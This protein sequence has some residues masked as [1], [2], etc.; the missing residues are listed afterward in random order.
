MSF[1]AVSLQSGSNGNAIFVQ[2]G[3]VNLL[4]D[5]GI[6]GRQAQLRLREKT[7]LDIRDVAAM[8]I[9]H[10]HRDHITS[11][12]IFQR[13]FDLP[14]H[15]SAPTLDAAMRHGLGRLGRVEHFTPG[16]GVRIGA[17]CI[18][19]YPT[20]HDGVDG[21]CFVVEYA[22][23][24]L[25]VM[26]DLGHPFPALGDLIAGCDAVYLE[27]NYDEGMLAAGLYPEFLK[28]RIRG[29]G[30]HISNDEAAG[31]LSRHGR[32]LQWAALAHLSGDN[33]TPAV[34]LA[35]ARQALGEAL[36]VHLAGRDGP[37]LVLEIE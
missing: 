34:A 36:P 18:E 22:G 2:A 4:F 20:P 8:F 30:G 27:S 5:A 37:G 10:D 17:V 19:T 11:A 28:A 33:N 13:K 7:A 26:T 6:S 24:R 29:A 15:V 21:C 35:T 12:G 16:Q 9:S 25:G 14:M 1:R 32:R 31:L 23:R 3:E